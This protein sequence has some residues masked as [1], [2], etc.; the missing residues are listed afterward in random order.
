MVIFVKNHQK[1]PPAGH[2]KMDFFGSEW[3]KSSF[4][5]QNHGQKCHFL[6]FDLLETPRNPSLTSR[7]RA[8]GL[9]APRLG[10]PGSQPE[11]TKFGPRPHPAPSRGDTVPPPASERRPGHHKRSRACARGGGWAGRIVD[12]QLPARRRRC[13]SGA[14]F[15]WGLRLTPPRTP[16]PGPPSRPRPAGQGVSG[17]LGLLAISHL[18]SH[19]TGLAGLA[20]QSS[21][22][23]AVS[24]GVSA[25]VT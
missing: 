3:S 17:A 16:P 7:K 4:L 22:R 2:K 24:V 21:T 8:A 19:S 14:A 11:E 5:G 1:W 12:A 9:V 18:A 25:C 20:R 15:A 10:V 13:S 6:Q 23:P